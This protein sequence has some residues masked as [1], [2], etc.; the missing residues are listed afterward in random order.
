MLP[1]GADSCRYALAFAIEASRRG[2]SFLEHE[3][4]S[5]AAIHAIWQGTRRDGID[6]LVILI[7]YGI[8]GT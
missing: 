4:K 6:A 2:E 8:C 1:L 3:S 5:S 7:H